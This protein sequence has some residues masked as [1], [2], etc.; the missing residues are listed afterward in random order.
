MPASLIWLNEILAPVSAKMWPVNVDAGPQASPNEKRLPGSWQDLL[1]Q[2]KICSKSQGERWYRTKS[3][4]MSSL[5]ENILGSQRI[6]T[7]SFWML[8]YFCLFWSS[9]DIACPNITFQVKVM[10][11]PSMQSN[12]CWSDKLNFTCYVK[13]KMLKVMHTFKSC[14]ACPGL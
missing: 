11:Y 10:I 13:G 6:L 3:F 8:A 14:L 9:A 4:F 7:L 5:N 12:T 1:V 2:E